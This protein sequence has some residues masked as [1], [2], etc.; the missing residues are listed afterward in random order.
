MSI[1]ELEKTP[2]LTIFYLARHGQ[3]ETNALSAKGEQQDPSL[4]H[5]SDLTSLGVNQALT[6]S[7]ELENT[8]FAAI[9]SSDATR[10]KRTAQIVATN[11]DIVV[12]ASD[13]IRETS[14]GNLHQVYL[15]PESDWAKIFTEL[16]NSEKKLFKFT[17]DMESFHEAS[18]RFLV[19]IHELTQI[20]S[21]S[22][23]L[24]VSHGALMKA[25]LMEIDYATF[26]ELSK[27]SIENTAYF[28]LENNDGNLLVRET[29]GI[30]K[31]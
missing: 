31:K 4:W 24:I 23:V 9:F 26:D 27:G 25:L 20:Y 28:V 30:H 21:G 18:T 3:S 5:G 13:R 2:E 10:A 8:N 22:S 16:P 17:D 6:L 14:A 15:N 7:N 12:T 11:R 29:H 19:F 1:N